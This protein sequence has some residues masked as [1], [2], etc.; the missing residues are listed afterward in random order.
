MALLDDQTYKYQHIYDDIMKR[1]V[2]GELVYGKRL[3]PLRELGMHYDCN[4]H[5]VRIALSKLVK[6]GY[7]EMRSG[8]GTYVKYKNR[9]GFKSSVSVEKEVRATA[10]LGVLLPV[11]G[12]AKGSQKLVRSLYDVSFELKVGLNVHVVPRI[13]IETASVSDSLMDQGCCAVVLPWLGE[14]Q[15]PSDLHN[16]I[17]ASRL[18]VVVADPVPGLEDNYFSQASLYEASRSSVVNMQCRY[19]KLLEYKYI[20]LLGAVGGNPVCFSR[21]LMEYSGWCNREGYETLVGIQDDASDDY[22]HLVERWSAYKGSVAVVACDDEIADGFIAACEQKGFRV[23]TDFAVL[24]HDVNGGLGSHPTLS[25][26]HDHYEHIAD[27]L[28][29][30]ACALGRGESAQ[31]EKAV[32]P[33][34]RVRES[35]GG[36]HLMG[37]KVDSMALRLSEDSC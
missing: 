4:Y 16:F 18:P 34:V 10:D 1:I 3:Q 33:R 36:R 12:S 29:R 14:D 23:P 35:C 26:M 37:R 27:G 28:I 9:G 2:Q 11:R 32:L 20:A 24:G 30:H 8:S 31:M 21:K 6:R 25:S 5:T 13:D 15:V 7:V 19:F 17:R 22:S